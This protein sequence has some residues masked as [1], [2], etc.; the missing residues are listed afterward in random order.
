[1]PNLRLPSRQQ[2]RA[3]IFLTFLSS[4]FLLASCGD[5]EQGKQG[6]PKVPVSVITVQP[7]PTKVFIDLPGRV[8][9]V[10]DA[11][12]RARVTG[13]VEEINF[14]Q[15]SD[16]KEGQLLFTIDPAPYIAARDQAA[17]QLK[18]AQADVRSAKLLAERYAK[19]VKANAVSRQ[20]YDNALAAANQGE[21]AVAAAKANLQAAEINLGYTKVTSPIDGRI[22]E[23]LVTEGALVSASSATEMAVVQQLDAVYVDV[24]RSTAQLMRLRKAQANGELTQSDDGAALAQVV[25]DDGSVYKHDG[26][27]LFSGVSVDP[28]TGQVT[29][30]AKFDNPEHILLPGMY[31]RVRLLQGV[32]EKALIVPQQA[33]QRTADGLNTLMVVKEGKV[34]SVAVEVGSRVPEGSIIFKGLNPGDQVIVEGFQKIGPGAAVQAVPWEPGKKDEQG[35]PGA[36]GKPGEAGKPDAQQGAKP[37]NGKQASPAPAGDAPAD[38]DKKG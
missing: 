13:I 6:A 14:E 31:V 1:M 20:E 12:I 7:K 17:A 18:Q 23:S 28:T 38:A 3:V 33:I 32:D 4:L 10:K 36:P 22:G 37:E 2:V 5:K 29:L 24:T 19:L 16:V 21:A 35:K 15:G 30:R 11:Q 8:D 34:A 27:L 9:A 25:L 26:K